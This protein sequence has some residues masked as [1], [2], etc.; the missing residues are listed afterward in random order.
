M[1][2]DRWSKNELESLT[3]QVLNEHRSVD[4]IYIA[5]RSRAA[6]SNQR[7][8]LRAAG[9]LGSSAPPRCIRTW[10]MPELG[11][12]RELT[13][14]GFTAE[15]IARQQLLPGRS[16][17]SISKMMGRHGLGNPKKKAQSRHAAR[18]THNQKARLV[19]YLLGQGRHMPTI[20]IARACGLAPKTIN[21]YRRRLGV[22]LSWHEARMATGI[23]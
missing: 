1:P 16:K 12:L 9:S 11:R 5:G 7:T 10:T 2:G 20:M 4:R 18:L 23:G 8:R 22:P 6:I 17:Y 3:S 15:V 14:R 19:N 13:L 21:A